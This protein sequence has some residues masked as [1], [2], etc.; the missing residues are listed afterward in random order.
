MSVFRSTERPPD[1][2]ELRSFEIIDLGPDRIANRTRTEPCERL[3]VTAGTAQII[4][5]TGT[6][7]LKEGQFLDIETHADFA[8][9]SA[10][11]TSPTAQVT[12]LC[13]RWGADISGCGLFRVT[14]E[15]NPS[16]NGDPVAYPKNTRVDSHYHDCDE[17]WLVLE[18]RAQVIVGDTANE[19]GPG[20][21]I[22]IGMG[23]HHDMSL[24]HEPVKAVYFETTLEG[25]KRVGHLWNH[26]HGPAEPKP[27][28]V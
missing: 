6:I 1:W 11:A 24:A 8:E 26:T 19:M 28:R 23:H 3:L 5:R 7:V 10:R 27:E 12:R 2:C 13:G 25:R 9:W 15:A 14:G 21:C 4:G 17:Y 18:G 22:S 16:D 20:D